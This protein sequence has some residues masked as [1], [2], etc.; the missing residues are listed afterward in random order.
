[1]ICR[2]NYL[3]VKSWLEYHR[4]VRQLSEKTLTKYRGSIRHLLEWADDVPFSQSHKIRPVYPVYLRNVPVVRNYKPMGC[5]LSKTTQ[6][7][8]CLVA[9]NFF[10]WACR[11]LNGYRV[12]DPIWIETLRPGRQV[13]EVKERELYTLDEVLTITEPAAGDGLKVRRDKAA[14]ALLF[15]SGMRVG[16]LVTLPVMALDL[17]KLAVKQWPEF[18]VATKNSKAATTYLLDIPDLL[19]VVRTWDGFVRSKLPPRAPWYARLKYDPATDQ[20]TLDERTPFNAPVVCWW[21]DLSRACV[22]LLGFSIVR[23]TS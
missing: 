1:M 5:T 21:L 7:L 6:D 2:Q 16:A 22:S 23:L 12:I 18:G 17:D 10:T 20:V 9:R 4:D 14:V 8:A 11:A 15:L 19:D 3:D 13:E